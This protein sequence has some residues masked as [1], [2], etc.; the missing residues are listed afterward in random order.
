M[1]DLAPTFLCKGYEPEEGREFF[2]ILP[3]DG[4][5][6]IELPPVPEDFKPV[7][8]PLYTLLGYIEDRYY[9]ALGHDDYDAR[10]LTLLSYSIE[11]EEWIE[12]V[13]DIPTALGDFGVSATASYYSVKKLVP[14]L[15]SGKPSF[16]VAVEDRS[17]SV[18][19]G[20]ACAIFSY[21]VL[22]KQFVVE[23]PMVNRNVTG[24]SDRWVMYNS[25]ASSRADMDGE[26]VFI[27]RS[28]E[29]IPVV[30]YFGETALR[31]YAGESTGSELQYFL[32]D[33][34][35]ADKLHTYTVPIEAS[36]ASNFS[37]PIFMHT[38]EFTASCVMFPL[39][40]FDT[41]APLQPDRALFLD[42]NLNPVTTFEFSS[43][44]PP[45]NDDWPPTVSEPVMCFH[46][47]GESFLLYGHKE[48]E[49][50]GLVWDDDLQEDVIGTV[51][52]HTNYLTVFNPGTEAV[53]DLTPLLDGFIMQSVLG[54]GIPML[55]SGSAN[56]WTALKNTTE[57]V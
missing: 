34:G 29:I 28:S 24:F 25:D 3:T 39:F 57:S 43:L 38:P 6:I 17:G 19:S 26:P 2:F 5:P 56:F 47:T 20:E 33:I 27:G 18:P 22:A 14:Y 21:D 55:S 49:G 41:Y 53:K 1:S 54:S 16:W 9:I 15:R 35:S 30:S 11:T 44:I 37:P 36:E 7:E 31:A 52:I 46:S 23:M 51:Y 32:V 50:E 13:Y 4:S 12:E 8:W 42:S 10:P 40:D 45:E 48:E